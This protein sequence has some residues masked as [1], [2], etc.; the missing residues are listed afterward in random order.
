[1]RKKKILTPAMFIET[2]A[3]RQHT[4]DGYYKAFILKI[5]EIHFTCDPKIKFKVIKNK[6]IDMAKKYIDEAP[7]LTS[8]EYNTLYQERLKEMMRNNK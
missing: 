6:L 7:L 1:M 2:E 4:I 8:E 3:F 5:D